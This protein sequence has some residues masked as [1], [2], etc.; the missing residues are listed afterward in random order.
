MT[1]DGVYAHTLE[2]Q[3]REKWQ[4]LIAHLNETARRAE[5]FAATFDSAPW[6]RLVGLWHDLGKYS[7]AFQR[8]LLDTI[9]N[10]KKHTRVNH[11]SAGAQLARKQFP[12]M[13]LPAA[14]A[15]AGHH[16]GLA[17]RQDLR[18]RLSGETDFA[19]AIA[20]T[21]PDEPHKNHL[22]FYA[23]QDQRDTSP[24]CTKKDISLQNHR[25]DRAGG[26]ITIPSVHF[27]NAVRA[28]F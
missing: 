26:L 18:D 16:A 7:P 6:S 5:R 14:F 17:D 13:W 15:I 27:L 2:G 22:K 12:Q 25:L 20:D 19:A 8:K 24:C 10:P 23:C 11:S 1:G 21:I 4:P 28:T 9:E 3:P